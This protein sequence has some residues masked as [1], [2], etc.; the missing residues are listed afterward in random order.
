[1]M[2]RALLFIL[3]FLTPLSA[4]QRKATVSP[5]RFG[6]VSGHIFAITKSGD[7]KPAR[8]AKVYLL[9]CY[10]SLKIALELEKKGTKDESATLIYMQASH[11]G[12]EDNLEQ[13][14]RDAGAKNYWS[15]SF[16]CRKDL[17][18]ED[19]AIFATMQWCSDNKKADQMPMTDA[20]EE[21][22]FRI[23]NVRPGVY[24]LVA[25]GQAGF[26]DAFWSV[27]FGE[28][29]DITVSPGKETSLKLASP[30]KACLTIDTDNEN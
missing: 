1:M 27:G 9:W 18:V 21:G 16:S 22:Y 15:D 4:Q 29:D 26:N 17:L 8:M 28:Q 2:R 7:L 14:K 23:M 19:A 20:D 12:M 5:P 13:R 10:P 6:V 30:E 25:R 3:L 11:K 24:R